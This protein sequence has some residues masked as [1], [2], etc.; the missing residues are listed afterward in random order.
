MHNQ[1]KNNDLPNLDNR[2]ETVDIYRA[3]SDEE[4]YDIM[5]TGKFKNNNNQTVFEVK[6]FGMILM[7]LWNLQIIVL[8]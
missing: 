3:V 2:I 4:Y 7:R 6:E 1:C 8:M 5:V